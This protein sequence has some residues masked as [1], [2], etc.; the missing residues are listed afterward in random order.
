MRK[1]ISPKKYLL[2]LLLG[3]L[4]LLQ[5]VSAFGA[6][7]VRVRVDDAEA[8]P[9]SRVDM[10][11]SVSGSP[12]I[13]GAGFTV[14]YPDEY[15]ELVDIKALSPGSFSKNLDSASFSWLKGTDVKGDFQIALLSFKISPEAEGVYEIGI[16][17]KGG[18]AGNLTNAAME[19]V[20]VRFESGKLSV[21]ACDGAEGCPSQ[22][23]DDLKSSAWY[24]EA[25]DFVISRGI[26]QGV[27]SRSF[28]PGLTASRATVVTVLYRLSGERASGEGGV[29]SDVKPGRWYSDAVSW[30]TENGIVE[31]YGDGRFGPNHIVTREQLAAMLHR[32]AEHKALD[33]SPAGSLS[34]FT[35]GGKV[36]SWAKPALEWA[37]GSGLMEGRS[38]SELAPGGS[39]T[40]AELAELMLRWYTII[41]K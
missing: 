22:A 32:W 19:T 38:A 24:H 20:S 30:A 8:R 41:E 10:T 1:L 27:D 34:A 9:G 17:L 14:N 35:D 26:M 37:V 5:P 25:V 15:M 28:A 36:S 3:L 4:L 7:A 18:L 31:G 11:V 23:F 40:R 39:S 2:S 6:S 13:S 33:T 16:G 29:Y 21:T 12:G